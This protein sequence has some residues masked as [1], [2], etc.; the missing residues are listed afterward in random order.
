MK[1][2]GFFWKEQRTKPHFKLSFQPLEVHVDSRYLDSVCYLD[3]LPLAFS[4][5]QFI[6]LFFYFIYLILAVS[7]WT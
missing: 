1:T 7:N 2:P 5:R 3:W 6:V 4:V